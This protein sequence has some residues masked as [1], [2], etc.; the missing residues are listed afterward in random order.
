[1]AKAKIFPTT[2]LVKVAKRTKGTWYQ[3]PKDP[4]G[5]LSF[6]DGHRLLCEHKRMEKKKRG[7]SPDC[8]CLASPSLQSFSNL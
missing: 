1:M 4:I 2:K 3:D 5:Q 8:P 6:W 7:E